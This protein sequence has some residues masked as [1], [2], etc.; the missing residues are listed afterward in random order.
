MVRQYGVYWVELNPTR[1]GEMAKTRPC[2]VV[3]PEELNMYLKTVIIAPVT[4]TLRDYP[5]RVRC[6]IEGREGEIAADQ[7]RTVD[8]S[9]LKGFIGMLSGHETD[10]LRDVF[11]EMLC[12]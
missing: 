2:V 10:Q 3:S 6:R 1:G 8:K 5:Y 9:R 12:E 4:S 7:V 11:R